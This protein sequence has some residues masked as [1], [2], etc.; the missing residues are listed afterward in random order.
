MK[1][2]RVIITFQDNN[3]FKN[4]KNIVGTARIEI[5]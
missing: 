4:T 2:N 5:T 3:N 1:Y